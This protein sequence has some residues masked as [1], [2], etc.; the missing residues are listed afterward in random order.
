MALIISVPR[1]PCGTQDT[2]FPFRLAVILR[3]VRK[4]RKARVPCRRAEGAERKSGPEVVPFFQ[5]SSP[6]A[7]GWK[8][9]QL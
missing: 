3:G 5:L 9:L 7:R 2:S 8:I 1:A 6:P 4:K